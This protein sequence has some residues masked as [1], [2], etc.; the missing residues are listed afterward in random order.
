M[1]PRRGAA[2][3]N[4]AALA[5]LGFVATTVASVFFGLE[6]GDA[7]YLA[8]APALLVALIA[9][10]VIVRGWAIALPLVVA[11]PFVGYA[12]ADP[13]AYHE[14][15]GVEVISLALA[16]MALATLGIAV[17]WCYRRFTS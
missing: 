4:R 8:P 11:V 3:S 5:T 9:G 17:G 16:Q 1:D 7:W 10:A 13:G 14:A 15:W 6:K 2:G 12:L